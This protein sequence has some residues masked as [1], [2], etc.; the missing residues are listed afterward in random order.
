MASGQMPVVN[1]LDVDAAKR[2]EA[3]AAQRE[4]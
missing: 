1:T 4:V 2:R 3:I